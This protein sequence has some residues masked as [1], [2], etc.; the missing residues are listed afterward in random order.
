LQ[1]ANVA[2]AEKTSDPPA[3]AANRPGAALLQN[4]LAKGMKGSQRDPIRA[5][6]AVFRTADAFTRPGF[7]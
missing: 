5:L 7:S 4:R 2:L 6:S 1:P 3:P